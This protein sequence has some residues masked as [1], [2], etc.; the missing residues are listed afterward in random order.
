MISNERRIVFTYNDDVGVMHNVFSCTGRNDEAIDQC[1]SALKMHVLF[2]KPALHKKVLHR[3]KLASG[4]PSAEA[5]LAAEGE[6]KR[7]WS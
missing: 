6:G 7:Y 4:K 3:L 2:N 5:L 1:Q